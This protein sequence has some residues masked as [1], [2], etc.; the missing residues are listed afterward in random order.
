MQV[1]Q[2]LIISEVSVKTLTQRYAQRVKI[3]G[4]NEGFLKILIS[5]PHLMKDEKIAKD[6]VNQVKNE[7]EAYRLQRRTDPF[8][9]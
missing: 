9:R 2:V 4:A 5:E 8:L 7:Q 1:P 3:L 6:N